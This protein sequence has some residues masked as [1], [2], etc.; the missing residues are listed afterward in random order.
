MLCPSCSVDRM[1]SRSCA[2]Y[3]MLRPNGGTGLL[4]I[5][6][7]PLQQRPGKVPT[8]VASKKML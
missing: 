7:P 1:L 4:K 6:E 3:S 8:P 2:T 5:S